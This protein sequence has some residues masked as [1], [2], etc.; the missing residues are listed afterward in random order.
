M[1]YIFG[2]QS[3]NNVDV[4]RIFSGFFVKSPHFV[5]LR[6]SEVHSFAVDEPEVEAP[7]SISSRMMPWL[8][9]PTPSRWVATRSHSTHAPLIPSIRAHVHPFSLLHSLSDT[10][11]PSYERDASMPSR[12]LLAQQQQP[13]SL[14]MVSRL[15]RW[16]DAVATGL[17]SQSFQ[18]TA[19]RG[20]DGSMEARRRYPAE[21]DYID[22]G[23]LRRWGS[24]G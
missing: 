8:P 13:L 18:T 22:W 1:T 10:V 19:A 3:R 6:R 11:I 16:Q 14:G 24:G 2:R 7:K 4:A 15:P 9:F 17:V 5:K 12:S 23:A 21:A 20:G